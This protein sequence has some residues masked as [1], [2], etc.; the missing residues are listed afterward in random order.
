MRFYLIFTLCLSLLLPTFSAQAIHREILESIGGVITPITQRQEVYVGARLDKAIREK[1]PPSQNI[2]LQ[3]YVTSIGK[4]VTARTVTDYPFTFTV[5][6]DTRTANAFAAPGGFIYITTGLINMMENEAQLAAVLSHESAH[7]IRR[8]T[9]R[10]LQE[11]NAMDLAVFIISQ[12]TDINLLDSA[13]TQLGEFVLFQKFSREDE[14]E[15]DILGVQLMADAGYNPQGLV[16]LLEKMN[17]LESRGIYISFLESHPTSE[18][19]AAL[20]REYI[21]RNRLER[22]GQIMD[23]TT[24]HRVV[25]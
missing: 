5:L 24:F 2:A 20:I 1:Y 14:Y 13:I 6:A 17:A 12:V 23:T 3:E 22:R 10:Q 25:R 8:H 11:R 21:R 7:V 19:R 18:A 15:A 9:I 4:R 16:Q